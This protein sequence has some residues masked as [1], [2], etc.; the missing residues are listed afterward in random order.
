MSHDYVKIG[1]TPTVFNG[2]CKPLGKFILD[3]WFWAW[4]GI[5]T[6]P[7]LQLRGCCR[8]IAK[9]CCKMR[10]CEALMKAPITCTHALWIVSDAKSQRNEHK[11]AT[12]LHV[13]IFFHFPKTKE[14]TRKPTRK[15]RDPPR[16]GI[17]HLCAK[18]HKADWYSGFRV[19]GTEPN[20][21]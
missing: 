8:T 11:R 6:V 7:P 9:G 10:K 2:Q 18:N 12:F 15:Q 13:F 16:P 19:I 14:Q 21:N 3:L 20:P 5:P 4:N 1:W 17:L